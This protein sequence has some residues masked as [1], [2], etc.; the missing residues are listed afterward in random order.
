MSQNVTLPFDRCVQINLQSSLGGGE[1]YTAAVGRAMAAI[2]LPTEIVVHRD[3]TFWP[4]LDCGGATFIPLARIADLPNALSAGGR[5]LFIVHA[6]VDAQTMQGLRSQGNKVAAF[7]HMPYHERSPALIRQADVVCAV[8]G[9]VLRTLKEKGVSNVFP[10]PFFGVADLQR[11]TGSTGEIRH[12]NE[13]DWDM[14]KFRDRVLS[15]VHPLIA[16]C[17]STRIHVRR[18]GITLGLVS[19][20]TTIKQFPE[21]FACLTPV[22]LDFPQINIAVFGQ[23]GYKSVRDLKRALAPLGER[24]A[25]WGHQSDVVS[26]YRSIDWLMSGLPEKEALGLNIIEAQTIGVPVLAVD[27][28]PFSETVLDGVTGLRYADPRHDAGASFRAAIE[29]I[30]A[31]G[32]SRDEAAAAQHLAQFSEAAFADRFRALIASF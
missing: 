15:W 29:T 4:R 13:Y 11:K 17:R 32:F 19:R 24:V 14:R 10:E 3:A 5:T 1:I 2:S 30:V 26:V 6:G 28:Q 21:L 23:G 9:Y 7:A 20:I 16:G 25:Y 8:S 22:L 12:G 27:A 18:P 31:G